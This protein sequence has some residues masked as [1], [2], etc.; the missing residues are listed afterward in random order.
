MTIS[1]SGTFIHL[2]PHAAPNDDGKAAL[3]HDMIFHDTAGIRAEANRGVIYSNTITGTPQPVPPNVEFV[4]CKPLAM[5]NS[6]KTVSTLGMNDLTGES[7]LY[8]EDNYFKTVAAAAIDVDDYCR[9]V[10]RH[11][12]FDNSAIGSHGA[13]TSDVGDRT[14]ELYDNTFIFTNFGDCDGSK[15]MNLP[16]FWFLRGGT[17]I[18]A[19][20]TGFQDMSS[21][22]W[23]NK[24]GA[25]HDGHEHCSAMARPNP[26][27]GCGHHERRRLSR[28]ASDRDGFC[29]GDWKGRPRPDR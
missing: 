8:I 28:A 5:T 21:C 1:G 7:N 16:F 23:G 13:D 11:N 20:N 18:I 14:F 17:G 15:T 2:M 25:C 12:T 24:P 4:Q 22:A 3:I 26:C 27:W 10:I 19:D 6:W 9:G 29:D